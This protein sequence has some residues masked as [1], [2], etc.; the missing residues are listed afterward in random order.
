MREAFAIP[1]DVQAGRRDHD[2]PP[3][4]AAARPARPT[5]RGRKPRDEVVHHGHWGRLSR[6][7]SWAQSTGSGRRAPHR[8][9]ARVSDPRPARPVR[10][11]SSVPRHGSGAVGRRG[12]SSS[13]RDAG[14]DP[15]RLPRRRGRSSTRPR[16][17]P[18]ALAL[19]EAFPLLHEHLDA[20]PDPRALA[21]A[22]T[23]RAAATQDPVVLMAHIDVVPDRRVG[24]VAAPA[25]RRRDPRRRDLGSRHPR[26]QGL[27][28]R[29]LQRGRAAA[30]RRVRPGARRLAVLRRA[31]GGLRAG[32]RRPRSRSCARAASTPWFV[33]DEGGA[34]A[35]EAFPGIA[36]AARRGRRHA[37]RA[38]PRSSCAP[39]AAVATPRHPA[40][41]RPDRA[42]RPGRRTA[43]E[44]AVPRVA[45]RADAS[46]CSSGSRRTPRSP[47]R[48]LFANAAPAAAGAASGRCSAA[49]AEA[50]ALVRT[51]MA[52]TTLSGLARRTT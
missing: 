29:H 45:A 19:A 17:R 39:R 15:D 47:L 22:S 6:L 5:R 48:P 32:R 37:R 3:G 14:P 44:A 1:A 33:L 30:G 52:V 18:S 49:G 13:F 2:R 9:P 35:H 36:A 4:A 28:G 8:H 50:A 24:A 43:G 34:I 38:P 46:R 51:T 10:R 12:A 11:S 7:G 26:R 27:A 42:H 25:V 21:A 20:A 16:S 23:G 31:R 41:Q 40:P